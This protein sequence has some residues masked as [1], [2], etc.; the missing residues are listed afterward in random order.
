M[1]VR[2]FDPPP[3]LPAPLRPDL[4]LALQGGGAYGAFTW[5]V[6]DRL[7]EEKRFRPVAISGA[8]AGALNAAVL[9]SGLA[10][11]GREAARE[12]LEA[13]W[14]GVADMAFLKM[15]GTPGAHLQLDLMTR[16]LSPYQFNPLNINPLRDLLEK[17]VNF[18]SLSG[19]NRPG[20]FISATNV[21]TGAPRIFRESEV[22]LDVLL[23]ST[24]LPYLHHAVEIE[25]ESYWDGGF[26]SNPPVLPLALE[27]RCNTVLLIKLTPDSEDEIPTKAQPILARM[28]R[29]MFNAPLERDLDALAGMQAQLSRTTRRLPR[30]LVRLRALELSSLS[31]PA[32]L[33]GEGAERGGAAA[34]IDSLRGAGRDAAETMLRASTSRPLPCLEGDQPSRLHRKT[35]LGSPAMKQ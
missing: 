35:P 13:L 24:C 7:L 8:S 15:M 19:R 14:R 4:G 10:A 29:I 20:L 23:A 9:A 6:L 17:L 34:L 3:D 16:L 26:S 11:G 18:P 5:G 33:F 30:D 31:I 21:R 27:T 32:E 1:Y 12:A 25:G 28:R 22:T 2:S